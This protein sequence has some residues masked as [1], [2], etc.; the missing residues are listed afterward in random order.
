MTPT[1]DNTAWPESVKKLLENAH[2]V[3]AI[4]AT[5]EQMAKP[6]E[7]V[8]YNPMGPS[9]VDISPAVIAVLKLLKLNV[10]DEVGSICQG[11]YRTSKIVELKYGDE[12][13]LSEVIDSELKGSY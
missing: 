5:L 7:V 10:R 3:E 8:I 13:I 1:D 12:V 9:I 11:C 2:D 4:L 6:T